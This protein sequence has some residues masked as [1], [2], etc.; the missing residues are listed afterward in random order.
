MKFNRLRDWT[1]LIFML[2]L[3]YQ[4]VTVVGSVQP[5]NKENYESP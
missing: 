4:R 3:V 1:Q 2:H 5:F